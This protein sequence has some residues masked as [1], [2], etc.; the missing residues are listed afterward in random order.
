MKLKIRKTNGDL[1]FLVPAESVSNLGWKAGGICECDV[2]GEGIR[3]VR[4][5]TTHDRAMKIAEQ[6]MDEYHEV[7]EK[8]AKS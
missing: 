5:E 8:L 3:I 7:F 1:V 6:V 2:E 4:I